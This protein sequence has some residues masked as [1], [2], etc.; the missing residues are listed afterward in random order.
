M[1]SNINAL[2]PAQRV[3]RM[4]RHYRREIRYIVLYALVGGLISLSLPLG[5]QAIIGLIAGGSISASWGVLVFG[6]IVGA[7]L[8]GL[9]RILQL[10][11]MEHLQRRIFTDAALEF[12]LRIP[13]LNLEKLRKEHLPE[14]V[15]RFFDTSNIQKGLPKL[16]IDGTT[17]LIT[18]ILCLGV[19]SFYH[20]TFVTFSLLLIFVLVLMLYFTSS[21]GLSTSLNESKYKYKLV[22]WLEE[23]SR[24]AAT[25]KLAGENQYPVQVAD[26]LTVQYLDARGRHWRILMI[27][28]IG[29]LM[30]RVF[31]LSGFLI[32]G[33]LLVM[34][35]ELNLGQFVASEI[36]VLYVIDSV[37]KLVLLHE[38]GYDVLTATEKLGQ[39]TDLPIEEENGVRIEEFCK[40]NSLKVELRNLSYQF[41]DGDEPVLKNLN[42]TIMP[43]EKVAITGYN[44]A[45]V[46]TLMQIISV[47]KRENTGTLLF[48]ELPVQNLHLRS[49]RHHIGDLSSQEDIF[50]G[51]ILDNITLG[52][53][54]TN[55][56]EVL[57]WCNITGLNDF[58]RDQ[59]K[60]LD[61][62]MYPGGRNT[63]GSVVSKILITRAV[64]G[65]PKL[66][67]L[68]KPLNNLILQDRL[69][70]ATMLTDKKRPWTL[71]AATEDPIMA[72]LCE[73]IIVLKDGEF[74]FD[75]TYQDL[76]QTEHSNF[77]FKY[78]LNQDQ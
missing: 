77:I 33:S 68:E 8:T 16:L 49:V 61:T 17:A 11:I 78:N 64:A 27:Q 7:L 52:R 40:D 15:N 67:A 59:P 48:N 42:L 39:V 70:I 28:F 63:P 5:V 47:L 4:L 44:G 26:K 10:S 18:I 43:G 65:N 54:T 41:D 51:T 58:L 23:V 14:V 36:L 6:V 55:I 66:L 38:T 21:S 45:G 12:A 46:S 56:R 73:R 13:R 76:M 30:F 1:E 31:I 35:N 53:E 25:F 69:R 37:E 2:T 72:S 29:G 32:V 71:V 24:V 34:A 9:L 3:Y 57:E 19:L 75:G 60:G 20:P 22:H 74:V 62:E 50:K